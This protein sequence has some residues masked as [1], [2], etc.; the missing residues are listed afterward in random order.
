MKLVTGRHNAILYMVEKALK[1]ETTH[2]VTMD[3]PCELSTTKARADLQIE[4]GH[5][6]QLYLIDIKTLYDSLSNLESAIKSNEEKYNGMRDEIKQKIKN[7]T[8]T[9]GTI[10]VG[11]LG[12]WLS[13]NDSV[14]RKLGLSQNAISNLKKDEITSNIKWSNNTWHHHNQSP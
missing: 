5:S 2:K 8:I 6:R 1:H 12:S 4:I 3:R 13:Q 14:L 10:V 7:W 11:C 9:I